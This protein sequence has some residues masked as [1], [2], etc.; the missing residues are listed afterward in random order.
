[1]RYY[2]LFS[3]LFAD[4]LQ[5]KLSSVRPKARVAFTKLRSTCDQPLYSNGFV[6][7]VKLTP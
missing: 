2:K 1:M 7:R 6:H 3:N 5:E 4:A